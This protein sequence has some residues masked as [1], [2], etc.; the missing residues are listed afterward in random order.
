M[1]KSKEQ[2]SEE[3][4]EEGGGEEIDESVLWAKVKAFVCVVCPI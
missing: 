1:K 3:E 4:E 2:E